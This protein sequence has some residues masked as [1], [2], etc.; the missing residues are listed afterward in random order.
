MEFR[1]LSVRP[2]LEP[3]HL[4]A[5]YERD[6]RLSW[7]SYESGSALYIWIGS[8]SVS[9]DLKGQRPA[10]TNARDY[11]ETTAWWR[12]YYGMGGYILASEI[13]ACFCEWNDGHCCNTDM[14]STTVLPF[15][16]D[17]YPNMLGFQQDGAPA[18]TA[19]Q[20]RNFLMEED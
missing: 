6:K 3:R 15:L 5:R 17:H 4:K 2:K 20:I 14:L 19:R 11:F 13:A 1:R 10:G 7:G 18:H 8:A 9:M 12:R 16:K